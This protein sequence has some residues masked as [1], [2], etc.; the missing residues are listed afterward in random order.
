MADAPK[1]TEEQLAE[2]RERALEEINVME[3][4]ELTLTRNLCVQG[5]ISNVRSEM[6]ER[7]GE[8]SFP[9]IDQYCSLATKNAVEKGYTP[10]LYID[11]AIQQ[12]GLGTGLAFKEQGEAVQ[13]KPAELV[14]NIRAAADG[15]YT[16]YVDAADK[17]RPLTCP[18]AFD[19]GATWA[20]ANLDHVNRPDLSVV[21]AEKIAS[22]CYAPGITH[23]QLGNTGESLTIQ[24]A[25]LA[26]GEI[27]GREWKRLITASTS[28]GPN[29]ATGAIPIPQA[30]PDRPAK[31]AKAI[32]G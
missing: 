17:E 16:S 7:F 30:A 6:E 9:P 14:R 15:G 31:A 32:G 4:E 26:A 24:Q 12:L 3:H 2:M 8:G 10:D 28:L 13:G 25:G 18:L 1:F 29:E 20:A 5:T 21:Q 27:L 22:I 23:I 19:A 11:L